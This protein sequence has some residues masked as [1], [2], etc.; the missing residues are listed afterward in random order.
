MT[1][2]V[3]AAMME[4]KCDEVYVMLQGVVA[5]EQSSKTSIVYTHSAGAL[6][7]L[8]AAPLGLFTG[9]GS[10]QAGV[11]GSD[12]TCPSFAAARKSKKCPPKETKKNI[13]SVPRLHQSFDGPQ[14]VELA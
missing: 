6:A 4:A 9:H 8:R 12:G 14:M 13:V 11:N 5:P 7:P 1:C 10:Y 2:L 3:Q